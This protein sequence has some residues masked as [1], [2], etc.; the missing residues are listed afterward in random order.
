MPSPYLILSV[1]LTIIVGGLIAC[2]VD[3]IG[4]HVSNLGWA[5]L[6]NVGAFIVVDL[7]KI[8]FREMIG[9]APGDVIVG[10]GL[11]EP[12]TTRTEAEKNVTKGLRYAV[13][14][15]SVMDPEDRQHVVSVRSKSMLPAFFDLG[16]DI[17]INDGF[18]DRRA[19]VRTSM[20]VGTA[21]YSGRERRTKQMSTPYWM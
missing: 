21:P 19:G 10:D 7:L 11:I 20:L 13:H 9:E 6:F 16:T 3:S 18:I 8:K 15:E 2:L 1:L 14:N 5:V 17:N 4:L 12:P